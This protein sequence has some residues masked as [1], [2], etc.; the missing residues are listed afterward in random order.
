MQTADYATVVH[1]YQPDWTQSTLTYRIYQ[2]DPEFRFLSMHREDENWW[3]VSLEA[4]RLEFAFK[5]DTGVLN[6]GGA[7]GCYPKDHYPCDND[8]YSAQ[9]FRAS[10]A[11]IWVKDGVVFTSH[12]GNQGATDQL[13]VL[14]LNLHTYQ[15]FQRVHM[16]FMAMRSHQVF[17]HH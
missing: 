2:D 9:N 6:L 5:G 16:M 10:S 12:P 3:V 15:E 14:S 13:T 1:L 8:N 17:L 11:E 4:N 7:G